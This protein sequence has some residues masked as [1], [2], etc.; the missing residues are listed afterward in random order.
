MTCDET[1][2]VSHDYPRCTEWGRGLGIFTYREHMGVDRPT[3]RLEFLMFSPLKKHP[4]DPCGRSYHTY[5]KPNPPNQIYFLLFVSK[6]KTCEQ[7]DASS[8]CEWASIS[9]HIDL[10]LIFLSLRLS[11]WKNHGTNVLLITQG[12]FYFPS[13]FRIPTWRFNVTSSTFLHMFTQYSSFFEC[14]R[15]LFPKPASQKHHKHRKMCAKNRQAGFVIFQP[16]LFVEPHITRKTAGG[17]KTHD[18]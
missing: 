13:K 15:L 17:T 6:K 9:R 4:A 18:F 16:F 7:K 2:K 14:F 1:Q 5:G 11:W 12:P 10:H 3:S 8:Q